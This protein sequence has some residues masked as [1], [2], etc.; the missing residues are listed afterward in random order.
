MKLEDYEIMPYDWEVLHRG[1]YGVLSHFILN[2]EGRIDG[3]DMVVV[4]DKANNCWWITPNTSA[5]EER[6]EDLGP[7][8]DMAHA[9]IHFKL[10][11]DMD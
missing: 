5:G 1:S 9:I 2:L 3:W 10:V 7:Y 6:M 11:A 4:K 8:D